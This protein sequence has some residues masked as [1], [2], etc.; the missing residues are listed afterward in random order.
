[1]MRL[2][3]TLLLLALFTTA[4]SQNIVLGD[5]ENGTLDSWTTWGAPLSVVDNP[6]LIGNS[7]AKVALLDQTGGSWSGMNR[8]NNT[9]VLK[10]NTI[11]IEVDVYF[12]N[13]GGTLKLQMDNSVSGAA[14]FEMYKNELPANA[15]TKVQF[16]LSAAVA[17]DYKQIAFQSSVA[18]WLYLD[19]IVMIQGAPVDATIGDFENS[20][21]QGWSTW[22]APLKVAAN[23]KKVGNV[24]NFV[25]L[26]DQSGGGWSGM[27]RWA[28]TPEVTKEYEGVTV[29]VLFKKTG[30]IVKMMLDNSNSGAANLELFS[31]SVGA[32]EWH[33]LQ[34][35]LREQ[36]LL[37]Y[38]QIAF[39]SP[40]TDTIYFDNI[41]LKI[42]L[43]ED[44][45]AVNKTVITRET[46]GN[47]AYD[48]NNPVVQT[49]GFANHYNYTD[50]TTF[51]STNGY[52]ASGSDSSIRINNYAITTPQNWEGASGDMGM[53]MAVPQAY[54]GSWDTIYF[55]DIDISG[56]TDLQVEFGYAKRNHVAPKSESIT[57]LNVEVKIDGNAWVQLDTTRFLKPLALDTW[58]YVVLPVTGLSGSK[59]D[60]RFANYYNQSFL[61]DISIISTMAAPVSAPE[62]LTA[63][64]ASSSKIDLAWQLNTNGDDVLLAVSNQPI[65]VDPSENSTYNVGQTISDGV[66]VIYSGNGTTFN[67]EQLTSS[68]HYYYKLWTKNSE[69]RYSAGVIIDAVTLKAEPSQHA[70][71]FEMSDRSLTSISLVWNDNQG[72]NPAEGYVIFISKFGNTIQTPTDG[73]PITIDLNLADGMGATIV[74]PGVEKF[75]WNN[76]QH[77]TAYRLSIY[78]YANSGTNINYKTD[79]AP[80]YVAVTKIPVAN[81]VLIPGAMEFND[82][83]WVK[84]E[85]ETE[86]AI[87]RY[88]LDGSTPNSQSTIFR[89]SIK[90][91]ASTTVKAIAERDE[92]FSQI[93]EA[94]YRKA[95]VIPEV[96]APYFAPESGEFADS[97]WVSILCNTP[98]AS[99][100]FTV[101]G[102]EPKVQ[103]TIYS[104]AIRLTTT[105]TIKAISTLDGVFSDV[106]TSNYIINITPVSDPVISPLGGEFA[107]SLEIEIVCATANASIYYTTNGSEPNSQST[108]YTG[109]FKLYESATVKAIA[110]RGGV[111]SNVTQL[112]Y[113]ITVTVH[114]TEVS[115]IADLR[116]GSNAIVYRF[117]GEAVVT[118]AMSNRNQ[119]YIQD[120][121]GAILIDDT[122]GV[123]TTPFETG[124]G[125]KNVEGTLTDYFGLLEFVPSSDAQIIEQPAYN[126]VPAEVTIDEFNS[127]FE[128]YESQLIIMKKVRFASPATFSTG[129]DYVLEQNEAQG[130]LRTHFYNADYM[131]TEM[132]I[133]SLNITG[134]ALWHF[135]AAKIVPR[136]LSDIEKLTG[137][138][139]FN[140]Q[141]LVYGGNQQINVKKST[142]G[143]GTLWVYNITGQLEKQFQVTENN[144]TLQFA[145]PGLYVVKYYENGIY[146]EA[147]T[148]LI[149]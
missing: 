22:G 99:V 45:P 8:W 104:T 51:T 42:S 91:V 121:T 55:R 132:P 78:P 43:S 81:P 131:N 139:E 24:S 38:K 146:F 37:D 32:G 147:A 58:S 19:N 98:N 21:L 129:T 105:T 15:W 141:F 134:I 53:L 75:T 25:A 57:G 140:H 74:A 137:V 50:V 149:K 89:D 48:T 102:T 23:P 79:N 118:Y 100:H 76:L 14:N 31:D 114:P 108:I 96:D 109:K 126:P 143:T 4:F 60:V 122:E 84:M 117:T 7:S 115:T 39:Q 44:E 92:I 29:D 97:V 144:S 6:S 145:K 40:V 54:S 52:I 9:P 72:T 30:G 67:H 148:I 66:T 106:V 16:S 82:S 13:T 138:N 59:M 1:M 135:D 125:M 64:V 71:N 80:I 133:G 62:N 111:M 120:A 69:T 68:T 11:M 103:S 136:M 61:D 34:F 17:L 35:D 124:K 28:N 130:I 90:I 107:D 110:I 101:D 27:A 85:C 26:F 56:F 18:D 33:T 123:I 46:F 116:Q 2:S 113:T 47:K 70:T 142:N 20:T 87:I 12:R 94:R 36:T 65:T 5:F 41:T 128:A 77:S 49:K 86:F 95:D 93:V 10:P 88:T 63:V 73:I 119:K 3:F 112:T 83:L 127:N